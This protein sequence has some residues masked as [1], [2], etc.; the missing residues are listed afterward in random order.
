MKK[1]LYLVIALSLLCIAPIYAQ[2]A[3]TD[4]PSEHWA[5]DAVESL[6][7]R[8][9]L[10]GYPDGTFQ[11]K[12]TMSRYELAVVIARLLQQ[13][14][15]EANLS[16]YATKAELQA[17]KDSIPGP[18]TPGASP[19]LSPYATKADLATIRTLVDGFKDE[20]TS[21][22]VDV[23]QVKRDLA[24]LS[25]RVDAIEA[26]LRRV[27]WTGT[28]NVIA[29]TYSDNTPNTNYALTGAIITDQDGRIGNPI[30]NAAG[31]VGSS[32]A[33]DINVYRDFDLNLVGRVNENTTATAVINFG[34]Y[35]NYLNS[36]S[37]AGAS[38]AFIPYYMNIAT[39]MGFGNLT[40]GRFP[41]QLGTYTFKM[42]DV[43]SYVNLAKTDS[44]NRP[45]DGAMVGMDFGGV[46]VS[47]FAAQHEKVPMYAGFAPFTPFGWSNVY[48]VPFTQSAGVKLG[49]GAPAGIRVGATYYQGWDKNNY[50]TTAPDLME[51]LGAD[52]TM[53]VPFV[54]GAAIS[55]M[56]TQAKQTIDGTEVLDSIGTE[57]DDVA[58][59]GR[60]DLPLGG[61]ALGVGY[62]SIGKEF[63]APGAWDKIG[64]IN[65]P[66]NVIGWNADLGYNFGD[67]FAVK[68]G[69]EL[70]KLRN[71][72]GITLGATGLAKD[73]EI[74]KIVG[75]I[76]YKFNDTNILGLDVEFDQLD[77]ASR[78]A[79]FDEP[80]T[81]Y[82]TL[83]WLRQLG[84]NANLKVG[85][86]LIDHDSGFSGV[87]ADTS[88]K[89]SLGV[90]QLGVSF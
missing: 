56:W 17:V 42:P 53:P 7:A 23:D 26:E 55:G 63:A 88:Y 38:D 3:F 16:N 82:I 49:F 45:V 62:R 40:V 2:S 22:G 14:P 86:Q 67:R 68:V 41:L 78:P 65:N 74:M 11:G 20:L 77:A 79:G 61:L 15:E 46:D 80:T 47:L 72:G 8:G 76:N 37:N 6:Q 29:K 54:S 57:V 44:G 81:S 85:Y 27:R 50:L 34:N 9:I 75:G 36:S 21:L 31:H 24:A 43:D 66:V 10:V 30:N 39:D 89:G 87:V 90:V 60:L 83:G 32:A 84:D 25:A 70:L 69:G 51:V 18:S 12:R 48:G 13:L 4:V 71:P 58:W 1:T 19:D 28:F 5:Y 73:D 33:R 64:N 35:I 59:E 52:F